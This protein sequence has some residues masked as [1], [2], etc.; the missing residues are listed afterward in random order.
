MAARHFTFGLFGFA[1]F[2]VTL[3]VVVGLVGR[4]WLRRTLPTVS[5]MDQWMAEGDPL[6]FTIRLSETS[7]S[8]VE[9]RIAT[10]DRTARA[11]QDY[12]AIAPTT[13][14]FAPGETCKE[15]VVETLMDDDEGEEDEF[16]S[17]ELLG[18]VGAVIEKR[19]GVGNIFDSLA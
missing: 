14:I 16:L 12:V 6:R 18:A 7:Q 8:P 11:G 1:A 19:S 2:C 15:I 4:Q 10:R 13:V 17:L 3:S 5:I 9:V